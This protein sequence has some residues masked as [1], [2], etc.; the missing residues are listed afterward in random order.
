MPKYEVAV[1]NQEVRD[2]IARK[3]PHETLSD[4]WGT[5]QY[6]EVVAL[7]EDGARAKIGK[8]HPAHKGFVIEDVFEV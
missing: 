8:Q 5:T 2:A 1:F 4:A 3:E 7:N 6:I